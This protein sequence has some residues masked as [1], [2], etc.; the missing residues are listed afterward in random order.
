MRVL[1]ALGTRLRDSRSAKYGM[2][3]LTVIMLSLVLTGTK[4]FTVWNQV[5]AEYQLDQLG[6]ADEEEP[7]YAIDSSNALVRML[8]TYAHF[9]RSRLMY[10]VVIVSRST[11]L[12][13]DLVF[14]VEVVALLGAISLLLGDA[15]A[16]FG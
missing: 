7:K 2:I 1:A 15:A 10:P 6:Q 8:L 5:R 3:V 12:D 16:R 13:P 14:S 4:R 9:P 11:G